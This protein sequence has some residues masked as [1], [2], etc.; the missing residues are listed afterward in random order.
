VAFIFFAD[1]TPE[2]PPPNIVTRGMKMLSQKIIEWVR[3]LDEE[4]GYIPFVKKGE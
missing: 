1:P 2:P 3:S 4:D